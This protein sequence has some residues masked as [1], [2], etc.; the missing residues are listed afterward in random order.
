MADDAAKVQPAPKPDPASAAATPAPK[1]APKPAADPAPKVRVVEVAP[2]ARKARLRLRHWLV[3]LSFVLFTVLPS[4]GTGVYLYTRAADQYA[5]TVGFTVRQEE[6]GSA[7]DFLGG[8]SS[9]SGNSSSDTDILYEFIQSQELVRAVDRDLGLRTIYTRAQDD[10]VFR[11]KDDA[12]IE[13]LMEYWGRMVRV[14]Y[15][16]GTGLIEVEVRSF[17][18]EDSQAI[19]QDL[20]ER[21][22]EMINRL[23]EVARQDSMRYAKD[24][25]E[26]AI[27]RLKQAR[28]AMTLFR[29][30]TQIVDP[31]ADIKGQ[32]GLLNSLQAQLA[33]ALIGLDMLAETTNSNDPRVEQAKRRITVIERR[34]EDERN[35]LGVGANAGDETRGYA[36]LVGEFES[37]QVDRQFAEEA[38]VA[39]LSAHDVALSEARRKSR[40]LAAY[41]NP[42]LAETPLYPR[43]PTILAVVTLILFGIWAISVL[44]YYSLRDRR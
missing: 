44:V 38:Y 17:T 23:S 6:V 21:S 4:A 24:E 39:A 33:D 8:L 18:P 11:L 27:G 32:M 20:F 34:I 16:P 9:L 29:N 3:L 2:V 43:R 14:F 37:L 1:P 35:K 36:D 12:T 13:E 42:T 7:F 26:L 30:E 15:D 31:S 22:S 10:P 28:Q 41:L 40:Y 5:S 25:L 19:A